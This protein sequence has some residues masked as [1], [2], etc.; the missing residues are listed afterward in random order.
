MYLFFLIEHETLD[1]EKFSA[2]GIIKNEPEYDEQKLEMFID[3]I[4]SLRQK[5]IWSRSDLIDL[6]NLMIPEFKHKETG[7][8]LDGKM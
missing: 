5:G 3:T 1:M 6:F 7:K 8:F 2:I 4:H